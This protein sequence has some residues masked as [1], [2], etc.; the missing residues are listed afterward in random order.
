MLMPEVQPRFS[1][2]RCRHREVEP[3]SIKKTN[4]T[5]HRG[6]GLD[7]TSGRVF[8]LSKNIDEVQ[9]PS[10]TCSRGRLRLGPPQDDVPQEQSQ[11]ETPQGQ[12]HAPA[13]LLF[14]RGRCRWLTEHKIT[15]CEISTTL[16][17]KDES[18][19]Y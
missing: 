16:K 8:T 17:E 18:P 12:R 1:R 4:K 15:A 13:V 10:P 11:E 3:F 2:C 14:C 6:H 7:P 9:P 5:T 19:S